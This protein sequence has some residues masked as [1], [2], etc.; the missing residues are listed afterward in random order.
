MNGRHPVCCAA[1]QGGGLFIEGGT[2]TLNACN[3]NSNEVTGVSVATLLCPRS[4]R[5]ESP[6]VHMLSVLGCTQGVSVATLICLKSLRP[7]GNPLAAHLRSVLF[8]RRR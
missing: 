1:V 6:G 3:V 5:W 8:V 7:P 2:V 4:Q